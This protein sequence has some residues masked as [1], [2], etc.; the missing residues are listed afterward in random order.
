MA[1]LIYGLYQQLPEKEII[2]FASAAAFG[3]F[4]EKG[5]ATSQDLNMIL[6]RI[7]QYE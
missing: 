3:K 1:G 4:F 6:E 7:K 2:Q 5:D